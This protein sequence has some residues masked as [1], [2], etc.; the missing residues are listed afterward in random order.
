MPLRIRFDEAKDAFDA[1]K[2]VLI[3]TSF[4]VPRGQLQQ[5]RW[6]ITMHPHD[7]MVMRNNGRVPF[8]T[9]HMLGVHEAERYERKKAKR[10]GNR[11]VGL[12]HRGVR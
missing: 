3:R 6:G 9:R 4:E 7:W 1:I 12:P 5:N 11:S 10:Y 2:G 8:Y